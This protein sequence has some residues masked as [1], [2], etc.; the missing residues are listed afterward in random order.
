MGHELTEQWLIDR[1]FAKF[2]GGRWCWSQ[3]AR[4]K[5]QKVATLQGEP[6]RWS[7]SFGMD[8][9]TDWAGTDDVMALMALLCGRSGGGV[10]R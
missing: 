8:K 2:T 1:G 7:L 5:V 4:C 6:Q 3:D 10:A 9:V